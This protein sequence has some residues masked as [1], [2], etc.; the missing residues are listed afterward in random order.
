M[1]TLEIE[2]QARQFSKEIFEEKKV[3]EAEGRITD[4]RVSEK[5]KA[6]VKLLHYQCRHSASSIGRLYSEPMVDEN[7]NPIMGGDN[8]Q[9][10]RYS[11][12]LPLT[13]A[14]IKEG[15]K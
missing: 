5:V 15:K 4:F 12:P 11:L 10:I 9:L 6:N 14:I 1:T 7:G 13:Y 8:T 2:D 3:L